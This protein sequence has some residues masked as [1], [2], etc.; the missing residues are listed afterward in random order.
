[1]SISWRSGMRAYAIRH[2]RLIPSIAPMSSSPEANAIP[3]IT[4]E[5]MAQAQGMGLKGKAKTR[6]VEE[7]IAE[8]RAFFRGASSKEQ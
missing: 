7:K 8:A 2:P 6:F 3:F 1:M 5:F 4:A